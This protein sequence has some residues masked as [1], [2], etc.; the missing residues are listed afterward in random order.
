MN[1]IVQHWEQFM[2]NPINHIELEKAKNDKQQG[3]INALTAELLMADSELQQE[4]FRLDHYR[5][6]VM[7]LVNSPLQDDTSVTR[8]RVQE[9]RDKALKGLAEAQS[10]LQAAMREAVR[11]ISYGL[12]FPELMHC[13]RHKVPPILLDL[14][15]SDLACEDFVILESLPL[16]GRHKTFKSLLLLRSAV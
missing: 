14:W 11:Q 13:M 15:R 8:V 5:K 2:R 12:K 9:A 10:R 7:A 6:E 4:R 1:A 3:H 16:P